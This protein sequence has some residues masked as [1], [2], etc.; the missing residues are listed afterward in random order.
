MLTLLSVT[1]PLDQRLRAMAT[2]ICTMRSNGE[3]DA[4]PQHARMTIYAIEL[5]LYDAVAEVEEM[6]RQ[7]SRRERAAT[8]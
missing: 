3:W 6:Q 5:A 7:P 1:S 8:K 4:L 2:E